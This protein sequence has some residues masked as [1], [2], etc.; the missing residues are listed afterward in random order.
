M[1]VPVGKGMPKHMLVCQDGQAAWALDHDAP[2]PKGGRK[3]SRPPRTSERGSVERKWRKTRFTGFCG[4]LSRENVYKAFLGDPVERKCVK[5][6]LK[7][8]RQAKMDQ[9]A[10]LKVPIEQK[11]ANAHFYGILSNENV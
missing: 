10:F 9:N 3:A 4:V 6:V 8:C 7:G 2:P 5:R 11:C 1:E